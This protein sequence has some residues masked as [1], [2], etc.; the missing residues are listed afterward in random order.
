[1]NNSE[2]K[3]EELNFN[4]FL[5]QLTQSTGFDMMINAIEMARPFGP[6]KRPAFWLRS[7]DTQ[8]YINA[9]VKQSTVQNLHSTNMVKSDVQFSQITPVLTIEGH[10]FRR[11]KTRYLDA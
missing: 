10:L 9:L 5:I 3:F 7:K 8:E 6:N 4:G 1:M 11:N 2:V